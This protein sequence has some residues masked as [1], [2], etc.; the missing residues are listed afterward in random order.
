[1]RSDQIQVWPNSEHKHVERLSRRTLVGA[2]LSQAP[3]QLYGVEG[4]AKSKGGEP[5]QGPI[6]SLTARTTQILTN[7][8]VDF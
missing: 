3:G 1:M 5:S 2:Q 4:E 8:Q 6:P 7:Q